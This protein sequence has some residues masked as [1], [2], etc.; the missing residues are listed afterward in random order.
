MLRLLSPPSAYVTMS[1]HPSDIM[2]HPNASAWATSAYRLRLAV[3]G[4]FFLGF[5]GF[6]SPHTHTRHITVNAT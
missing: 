4:F 1:Q 2:A 6:E 3:F 5:H